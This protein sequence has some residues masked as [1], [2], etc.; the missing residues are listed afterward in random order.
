L[1]HNDFVFIR[2]R[3]LLNWFSVSASPKRAPSA[4][5]PSGGPYMRE[6][7]VESSAVAVRANLCS[8]WQQTSLV[9]PD[10]SWAPQKLGRSW[11]ND[12]LDIFARFLKSPIHE[13][14]VWR[15]G[16]NH[17]LWS[18]RLANGC[19]TALSTEPWHHLALLMDIRSHFK[20][21]P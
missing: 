14:L 11:I 10:R 5:S 3:L 17:T 1:R 2:F 4:E 9:A 21:L 16:N 13:V 15:S 8:T 18:F 20:T 7:S 6:S 19:H 12:R